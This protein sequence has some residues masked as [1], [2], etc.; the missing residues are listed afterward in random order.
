M[1]LP[2]QHYRYRWLTLQTTRVLFDGVTVCLVSRNVR[3][4]KEIALYMN[5]I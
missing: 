3:N 1:L 5:L 4:K 2:K